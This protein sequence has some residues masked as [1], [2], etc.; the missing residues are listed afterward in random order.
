MHHITSSYLASFWSE[1]MLQV[2]LLVFMNLL[3]A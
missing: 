1:E 2:N 3:G